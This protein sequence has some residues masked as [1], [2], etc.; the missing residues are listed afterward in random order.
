MHTIQTSPGSIGFSKGSDRSGQYRAG[1]AKNLGL[2]AVANWF[3]RI[4]N[5]LA[6][7]QSLRNQ[8]MDLLTMDER[9]LRDIGITRDAA[10][11]EAQRISRSLKIR[12]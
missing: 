10:H 9:T 7:R 1:F 5:L 2:K 8:R 4:L 6:E 3:V 12:L 11:A